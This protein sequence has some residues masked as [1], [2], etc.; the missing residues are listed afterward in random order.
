MENYLYK[1]NF[2]RRTS[3]IL[4]LSNGLFFVA[5]SACGGAGSAAGGNG[6]NNGGTGGGNSNSSDAKYLSYSEKPYVDTKY[7]VIEK[8][9]ITGTKK[10][11]TLVVYSEID[12][13]KVSNEQEITL[14]ISAKVTSLTADGSSPVKVP[15]KGIVIY[16]VNDTVMYD[17]K[18]PLVPYKEGSDVKLKI[19]VATGAKDTVYY[20]K[21][22][23]Q[24]QQIQ[25]GKISAKDDPAA[26]LAH[27]DQDKIEKIKIY[28]RF[29]KEDNRWLISDLDRGIKGDVILSKI[30]TKDGNWENSEDWRIIIKEEQII[31]KPEDSKLMKTVIDHIVLKDDGYLVT[32]YQHEDEV[33]EIGY[34]GAFND[35]QL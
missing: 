1:I 17:G 13:S 24:E 4:T 33:N 9:L 28:A 10:T 7:A 27:R 11:I 32:I 15:K 21:V 5:L 29:D 14:D 35:W 3:N 2:T 22:K 34:M 6:G 8:E 23:G 25:T 19:T 31:L 12:G 18:T 20:V 26:S 30:F 16:K